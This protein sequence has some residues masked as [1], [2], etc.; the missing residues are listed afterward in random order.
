MTSPQPP[1]PSPKGFT[2]LELSL[3]LF[4]IGLLVTA[5]LPRFGDIGGARLENSA[6][7]L[8]ALVRYV[9][10]EAAFSGRVYRI[11]YDLREQSYA[12]QV[13]VPSRG[14]TEFVAD[15]SPMS[16]PVRLPSG[17]AFADVHIAQAGRLNTGQVFTHFYPH[18]YVDPTVVHL[19]DQR[20]R[21]MTVM[22]PPVTGE[23]R[24]YEGYVDGSR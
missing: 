13:L 9:N 17:I 5:L 10:G 1:A 21:T 24:I 2:L 8:A 7:R 3:T 19:R 4:I 18:G 12:V 11:R 20:D 6:R 22:I 23:A 16:Q 14:A 15:P